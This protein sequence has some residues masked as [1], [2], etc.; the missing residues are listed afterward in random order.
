ML[1]YTVW[2]DPKSWGK[3]LPLG[4]PPKGLKGDLEAKCVVLACHQ[5]SRALKV[6]LGT[7]GTQI[8]SERHSV[9]SGRAEKKE[10]AWSQ[11]HRA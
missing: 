6:D 3:Q 8:S 5:S 2:A 1:D 10:E 7:L 9:S 11:A 4:V